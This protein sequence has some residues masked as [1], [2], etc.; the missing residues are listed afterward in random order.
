MSLG[1]AQIAVINP[2]K[3]ETLEDGRLRVTRRWKVSLLG[4]NS[5]VY[6]TGNSPLF[7]AYGTA[8]GATLN[9]NPPAAS[10]V[11]SN[12]VLVH[13]EIRLANIREG[14][15]DVDNQSGILE[16]VYEEASPTAIST[17]ATSPQVGVD[18]Y[19]TGPDAVKEI[20]ATY[21]NKSASS[22][23]PGVIGTDTHNGGILKEEK[24]EVSLAIRKVVRRY[25]VS[26][27]FQAFFN[28][29]QS[30][31]AYVLFKSIGSKVTPT[32]LSSGKTLAD[33]ASVAF[34]GGTAT[35]IVKDNTR[36]IN[37]LNT[38]EV[39]AVMRYDG[40]ALPNG[41]CSVAI[42]DNQD[43]QDYPIPGIAS[44]GTAAGT[45]L[46]PVVQ[47]TPPTPKRMLLVRIQE[48]IM[49]KTS[50]DTALSTAPF[51]VSQ[52]AYVNCRW[53]DTATGLTR[54]IVKGI[55]GFL[56]G[57]TTSFTSASGTVNKQPATDISCSVTSTPSYS[58]FIGNLSGKV[59]SRRCAPAYI[60]ALGVRYYRVITVTAQTN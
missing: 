30:G 3:L 55:Q 57:G 18:Q 37:G 4:M 23:T 35:H 2:P 22:F 50:A 26:G 46:S 43:Y 9:S 24:V 53:I 27:L 32:G 19:E 15:P 48:S 39:T 40:T 49:D 10:L 56:A 59:L 38:F 5:E 29:Q 36:D 14:E 17:S 25:V 21:V 54:T 52:W 34:Q 7:D 41:T 58:S 1:N 60:T 45:D 16:K 47:L 28:V 31:L 8:D 33:P 13:Q 11:Y 12:C 20:I 42:K 6:N 51:F 44:L